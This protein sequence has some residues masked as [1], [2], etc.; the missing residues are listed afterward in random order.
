MATKDKWIW[1]EN[2][3]CFQEGWGFFDSDIGVQLFALTEPEMVCEEYGVK[4][5]QKFEE[6]PDMDQEAIEFVQRKADEGSELHRKAI[7]FLFFHNSPDIG[8]FKNANQH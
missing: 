3:K 4:L 1:G 8:L 6:G 2:Q 7:E 5:L